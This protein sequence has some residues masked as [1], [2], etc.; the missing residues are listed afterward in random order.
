MGCEGCTIRNMRI[1]GCCTEGRIDNL[2]T[3]RIIN[4]VNN[5]SLIVCKYLG[6]DGDLPYC[7][8]FSKRKPICY[9]FY[10]GDEVVRRAKG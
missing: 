8:D 6:V 9:S 3:K 2:P 1:Q 4:K 5:A 10:C 7:T